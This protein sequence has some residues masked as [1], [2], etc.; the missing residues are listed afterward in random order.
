MMNNRNLFAATTII[1]A[2]T[3]FVAMLGWHN[4]ALELNSAGAT[5]GPTPPT[6]EPPVPEVIPAPPPIVGEDVEIEKLKFEPRPIPGMERQESIQ[7]P[8]GSEVASEKSAEKQTPK[9]LPADETAKLNLQ[10]LAKHA[11]FQETIE[12]DGVKYDV[13]KSKAYGLTH[14]LPHRG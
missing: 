10:E 3:A 2:V 4:T 13:W 9:T 11:D 8:N 1:L 14:I 6:P 5:P 12:K 7:G